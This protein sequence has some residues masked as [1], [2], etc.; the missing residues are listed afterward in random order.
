MGG[1]PV[2]KEV[3]YAPQVSAPLLAHG[4]HEE[5]GPQGR[6]IGFGE[7]SHHREQ[8]S[9]APPIIG[10]TRGPEDTVI[11]PHRNVRFGGEYGVQVSRHNDRTPGFQ[12]VPHPHDV[13]GAVRAE[14]DQPGLFEELRHPPTTGLLA[15]RR[16]GDLREL[17]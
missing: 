5:N 10:D 1:S 9:Q 6:H 2:T 11:A 14:I 17:H 7:S 12:A 8:R 13:A 16:G 3:L 4:G 15:E